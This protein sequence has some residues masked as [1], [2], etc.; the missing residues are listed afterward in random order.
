MYV[1]LWDLIFLVERKCFSRCDFPG[2]LIHDISSYFLQSLF[3]I[4]KNNKC[5]FQRDRI[6]FCNDGNSSHQCLDVFSGLQKMGT[7]QKIYLFW[8]GI[9][10]S[11]LSIRAFSHY[12]ILCFPQEGANFPKAKIIWIHIL[13]TGLRSSYHWDAFGKWRLSSSLRTFLSSY[14]GLWRPKWYFE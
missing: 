6:D 10:I 12:Y 14:E 5:S 3:A 9:N 7:H 8:A 13:S 2:K 4:A 1:L 11:T